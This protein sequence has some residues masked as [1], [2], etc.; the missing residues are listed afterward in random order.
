VE[1]PTGHFGIGTPA[2]AIRPIA[3]LR[4][5][6]LGAERAGV[7]EDRLAV[8]VEVLGKANA[9]ACLTQQPGQRR[10]ADFPWL[11]PQVVAVEFEQVEAVEKHS[12]RA[13][14]PGKRG[15]QALEVGHSARIDHDALAIERD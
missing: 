9:P 13:V 1:T 10:A 8:A 14:T 11:A 7:A 4:H 5:D 3:P 2:G 12:T 15:A 6:A